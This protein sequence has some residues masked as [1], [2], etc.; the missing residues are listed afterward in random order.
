MDEDGLPVRTAH[1]HVD[2]IRLDVYGLSP[3]GEVTSIN[4]LARRLQRAVDKLANDLY[5]RETHFILEL[6]QNA[7]DNSY[8]LGVAPELYFILLSEDPF[9]V[10]GSSG[11]LVTV[12]NET[13]FQKKHFEALCDV[14]V[15]TKSKHEGYI[16]EKGIGFKSV[17]RVSA[18]PHIFSAGYQFRFDEAPDPNAKIGF[19]VPY[20]VDQIPG[21]LAS[22]REQ[23]IIGLPL[24]EGQYRMVDASLRDLVPETILFLTKIDGLR[25]DLDDTTLSIRRRFRGAHDLDLEVNGAVAG[26]Y[27][28][29]NLS[30]AVPPAIAEPAREGIPERAVSVALPLHDGVPDFSVYAFLP[31]SERSGLPF[32]VNADFLLSANREGIHTDRAWNVWLRD[33]IAPTFVAAFLDLVNLRSYRLQAWR[34]I[35]IPEAVHNPFFRPVAEDI[36]ST[37]Q[38]EEVVYTFDKRLVR[39]AEARLASD[40]FRKLIGTGAP[41]SQLLLT[42]LV[43]PKLEAAYPDQLDAVGVQPLSLEE[44]LACLED[45]AW[46]DRHKPTWFASLYRFLSQLKG[47]QAGALDDACILLLEDGS[48]ASRAAR[49]VYLEATVTIASV[50]LPEPNLV[51]VKFVHAKLTAIVKKDEGLLRWLDKYL[52]VRDFAI[53]AF[54]REVSSALRVQSAHPRTHRLEWARFMCDRW[55][56]LKPETRRHLKD[57]FPLLLASKAW[58]IDKPTLGV[59]LVMPSNLDSDAGWQLVFSSPDDQVGWN[60]LNTQYLKGVRD[61]S[62][63]DRWRQFFEGMGAT[64][65]PLPE[66]RKWEMYSIGPGSSAPDTPPEYTYEKWQGFMRELGRYGSITDVSAPQWLRELETANVSP[67]MLGRRTKALLGWL[68][69]VP[70]LRVITKGSYDYFYYRSISLEYDTDFAHHLKSAAWFPSTKGFVRPGEAFIDDTNVRT[71]LGGSVSYARG[72]L[73]AQVVELLGL[74]TGLAADDVVAY[75][76]ELSARPPTPGDLNKTRP[77]YG[78]LSRLHANQFSDE[79]KQEFSEFPLMLVESPLLQWV[80][81]DRVLWPAQHES[82]FGTLYSY[83][84]PT[85][86]DLKQ[87]FTGRLG[88]REHVDSEAYANAL[89][90]LGTDAE[91]KSAEEVE[92]ALETIYREL[93]KVAEKPERPEWWKGFKTDVRIWTQTD[94]FEHP[95]AVFVPDDEDLKRQF[96]ARGVQFAWRPKN[97]TFSDYRPLYDALGLASLSEAVEV[98]VSN[99]VEVAR[100]RTL[101]TPE[102]KRAVCAF[103]RCEM[104][105]HFDRSRVDGKLEAFL[106]TKEVSVRPLVVNWRLPSQSVGVQGDHATVFWDASREMLFL[107]ADADES[108]GDSGLPGELA[109]KLTDRRSSSALE[110]FIGRILPMA[111]PAMEEIL[112]R[113]QYTLPPDDEAWIDQVLGG[114]LTLA[115]SSTDRV[116]ELEPAISGNA[117]E[118]TEPSEIRGAREVGAGHFGEIGQ[119]ANLAPPERRAGDSSLDLLEGQKH[120]LSEETPAT[121]EHE[122]NTQWARSRIDR[123]DEEDDLE[124]V[125][126]GNGIRGESQRG[127]NAPRGRRLSYKEPAHREPGSKLD[128]GLSEAAS[129]HRR[130]VERAGIEYVIEWEASQGRTAIDMN[131]ADANH[132]GWDLESRKAVDV[133]LHGEDTTL[134]PDRFVEV[135]ATAMHWDGYGVGLT[136]AEFEAAREKRSAYFLY[137]VER[138]LKPGEQR[139]FVIED[140]FGKIDEHVFDQGWKEIA[141][142]AP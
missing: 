9:G 24:K 89:I 83:L 3:G 137:V 22:Y 59:Q 14:G 61:S 136:P 114:Q 76:K 104:K 1:E 128:D 103:M 40:E 37:L 121:R 140:P 68:G 63:R 42:P 53:D 111:V 132:M 18:Q 21:A 86:P 120:T 79:T 105:N 27:W 50:E 44:I 134:E 54:V 98:S 46:L 94:R 49:N 4:P 139:L 39:P 124:G 12:N 109:R 71:V 69:R 101:L 65:T 133:E 92:S 8:A 113:R 72:P 97:F 7:E 85:Y 70:S 36:L 93:L 56:V 125:Q 118:G 131:V 15:T 51:Q 138:A 112:R 88:V 5:T 47:I 13:G 123:R 107:A 99:G 16:G 122:S 126:H 102:V 119:S 135:K 129:Q 141:N 100:Q 57:N 95:S 41:P 62:A 48:R 142:I 26:R 29:H 31:T 75:L 52:G 84:E 87:F 10:A 55:R 34:H 115:P 108:Q 110:D 116:E 23:T 38:E 90:Q 25:I 32:I 64:D 78:H 20:W 130:M 67:Q 80:K 43:H 11:A 74:K 127:T 96:E 35:P 73:P 17:F 60:V 33:E 6:I 91:V 77:V 81:A 106:R 19:I 66:R 2:R 30:C 58:T 45:G 82:V 28:L 117:L